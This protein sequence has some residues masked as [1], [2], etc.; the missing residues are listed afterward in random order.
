MTRCKLL[1]SW[2]D[3]ESRKIDKFEKDNKVNVC[4]LKLKEVKDGF[5]D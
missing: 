3:N 1:D 5:D 2:L 4:S